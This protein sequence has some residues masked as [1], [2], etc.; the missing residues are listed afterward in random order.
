MVFEFQDILFDRKNYMKPTEK[1]YFVRDLKFQNHISL[2]PAPDPHLSQFHTSL[3]I[4]PCW[5]YLNNPLWLTYFITSTFKTKETGILD[6][7]IVHILTM[8]ND[9]AHLTVVR[10]EV[11]QCYKMVGH[12]GHRLF[13]NGVNS[14]NV[15]FNQGVTPCFRWWSAKLDLK[16]PERRVFRNSQILITLNSE[17][18]FFPPSDES[19]ITC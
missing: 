4:F 18:F 12:P 9:V 15:C 17:D 2:L 7:G 19:Y 11:A 16:S 3:K 5:G 13:S 14:I 6:F 8:C 10:R 1:S